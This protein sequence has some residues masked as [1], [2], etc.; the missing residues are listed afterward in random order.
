M[1][2][3]SIQPMPGAAPADR[4]PYEAIYYII[5]DG[6]AG[7]LRPAMGTGRAGR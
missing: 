1:A 6:S 2:N 3:K 4:R 5:S 7:I